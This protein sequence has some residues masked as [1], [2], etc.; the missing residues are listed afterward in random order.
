MSLQVIKMPDVGEGVA[1][2]EIVE[3]QVSVGDLVAEDQPIAAV[4]TDKVTLEIPSPVNGRVV[5]LGAP[6]GSVLAVGAELIRIEVAGKGG[7]VQ[8]AIPVPPTLAAPAPRPPPDASACPASAAI[9][10]VQARPGQQPGGKPLASPAVRRRAED[11]GLDLRRINGSGPAG[12][13]EHT[14]L[15][16]AL[17]GAALP[18]VAGHAPNLAVDEVRL[19]GLNRV[20]AQRMAEASRRIAHFSY[21]DEVD[22]SAL[23][24]L[25]AALNGRDGAARLTILPFLVQA[26]VRALAAFPSLNAHYD[27]EAQMVR[28][29]GGI[30]VGIAT[31]TAAGLVVP[32]LRHAEAK[33]LRTCAAEIAQLCAA[34]RDGTA[35][36]DDLSGSTITVTSLGALGGLS[37]TPIINRP[38]VAII[39]VNKIAIRPVW[40]D[41]GFAPRKLMNLSSSF[42][43]RV[44]DGDT[45][46]RFVQH[47]RAL[48]EVP[49]LLFV[50]D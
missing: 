22:V 46:A 12:R 35:A 11:A 25:R 32:V 10:P 16:A 43:H 42:D 37:T 29:Y 36:R 18:T 48:L 45:A 44:V 6:L 14:D 39:G 27:D 5:A 41:R 1:E 49:A 40:R 24:E 33:D 17:H 13:I 31:Q 26:M 47:V 38:E 3:W 19:T 4:Q 20:I 2:A 8:A 9:Q 30:H 50:E 21:V 15:D 34:A 28:R 23:E 7:E